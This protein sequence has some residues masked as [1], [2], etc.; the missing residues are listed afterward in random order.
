MSLFGSS[1][2]DEAFAKQTRTEGGSAPSPIS[3]FHTPINKNMPATVIAKGV[4]LEGEFKSQGDVLI[5]G[6]VIGNIHTD[7][8]LT[9]GPEAVLKAGVSA[10][11]AVIAGRIE[12]N[13]NIKKRLELK[14]TAKIK[15]DIVCQTA[16]VESGATMQGNINCGEEAKTVIESPKPAINNQ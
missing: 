13:L 14:A 10:S 7:G 16:A 3:T 1:Q 5:E 9:V 8:L 12:G 4:K 2:S 15:G 11:D 6:E